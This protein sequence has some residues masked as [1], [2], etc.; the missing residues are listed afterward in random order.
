MT[1]KYEV[2]ETPFGGS[3]IIRTDE[4]NVIVVIPND[5]SNSDYQVYLA[6]LTE[7]DTK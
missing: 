5:P 4:T 1:Y 7:G 2:V 6:S 3:A